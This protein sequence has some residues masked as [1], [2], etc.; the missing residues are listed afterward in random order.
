M[1]IND[2]I[3]GAGL[4]ALGASMAFIASGFASFPGQKYGP[5]LF[6]S[7]IASAL[8]LCGG[9]LIVQGLR[10][11]RR[12][13]PWVSIDQV[14]RDRQGFGAAFLVIASILA[15]ILIGDWLGFLPIC[16]VSL[17][18]LFLWLGFRPLTV[19]LATLCATVV[20]WWSF[21]ELLRVP[22]PHGVLV[23]LL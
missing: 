2:S 19:A 1:K 22:L 14:M 3:L 9:A 20:I 10:A 18:T 4:L 15:H 5:S 6:P 17:A 11:R 8:M 13:E 7:L 23:G 21:A 12:G 16:V